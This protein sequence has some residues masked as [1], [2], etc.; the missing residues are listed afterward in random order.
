MR[1]SSGNSVLANHAPCSQCTTM[2]LSSRCTTM[3][4]PI[5]GYSTGKWTRDPYADRVGAHS[6]EDSE[7]WQNLLRVTSRLPPCEQRKEES[8]EEWSQGCPY[9]RLGSRRCFQIIL[10]EK[11]MPAIEL[12]RLTLPV[13]GMWQFLGKVVARVIHREDHPRRG[14]LASLT[15][16]E[17]RF[18]HN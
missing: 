16:S 6:R 4:L 12:C 1:T 9:Q 18:L 2:V 15:N 3:A 11:K 17:P 10:K 13:L 14:S 5:K 8:W 7:T